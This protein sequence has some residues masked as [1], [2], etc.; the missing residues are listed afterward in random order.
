MLHLD[1][2]ACSN[3][4]H[5]IIANTFC[6]D[7]LS[8][9]LREHCTDNRE[10]KVIEING[11]RFTTTSVLRLRPTADDDYSEYTCQAKHKSLQAHMPMAATVQLSVLCKYPPI[12]YID[13]PSS[14]ALGRQV[15]V[16][17]H[18]V[19]LHRIVFSNLKQWEETIYRVALK[20][21]Y[22]VKHTF[23]VSHL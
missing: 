2:G 3:S 23:F 5:A 8:S 7:L 22:R 18:T 16:G 14:R 15:C 19:I 9:V 13:T 21:D 10:D 1:P 20:F 17:T 6:F 4:T 11:K 12:L